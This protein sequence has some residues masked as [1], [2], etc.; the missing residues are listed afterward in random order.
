MIWCLVYAGEEL[1]ML[2]DMSVGVL[3]LRKVTFKVGPPVVLRWFSFGSPM[4][5]PLIDLLP[6][7]VVGMFHFNCFS[8]A[9]PG[10]GLKEPWALILLMKELQHHPLMLL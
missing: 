3:D 5:L 9:E 2:E 10:V 8:R 6:T 4:V 1:S 7:S